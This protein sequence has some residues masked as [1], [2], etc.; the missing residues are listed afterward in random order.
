[1][2]LGPYFPAGTYQECVYFL[3]GAF[4]HLLAHEKDALDL[5]TTLTWFISEYR[6]ELV[7]DGILEQALDCLRDCLKHW[8]SQFRVT[9]FDREACQSKGWRLAYNDYVENTEVI[10][11]TI[12]DLVQFE[13]HAD[14]A[15]KFIAELAFNERDPVKAAWFLEYATSQDDIYNP[16]DN[17]PIKSLI[18]NREL[19][20]QAAELVRRD[21][22]EHEPSPT[23]WVDTFRSLSL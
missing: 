5:T 1:M 7:A 9:H 15:E 2:L 14:L 23:Y 13:H 18:N 12:Y 21:I 22:V 6:E 17:G 10:A 19:L 20:E 4:T 16:P 8:T 11:K 3:P